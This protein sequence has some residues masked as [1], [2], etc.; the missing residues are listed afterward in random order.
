MSIED[1]NGPAHTEG[2]AT[3]RD[4]R[5]PR[6]TAPEAPPG[7]RSSRQ[8]RSAV[9]GYLRRSLVLATATIILVAAAHAVATAVSIVGTGFVAERDT[10]AYGPTS[11]ITT[12]GPS[13]AELWYQS[14]SSLGGW[15]LVALGVMLLIVQPVMEL[16]RRWTPSRGLAN[17]SGLAAVATA[18]VGFGVFYAFGGSVVTWI[19]GGTSAAPGFGFGTALAVLLFG[20]V[21]YG[22]PILIVAALA[23]GLALLIDRRGVRTIAAGVAGLIVAVLIVTSTGAFRPPPAQD[24]AAAQ[25]AEAV[26]GFTRALDDIDGISSIE[27]VGAGAT[28]TMAL[29]ASVGDVIS[30]ADAAKRAGEQ[31]PGIAIVVIQREEDPSSTA[32]QQDPARGPWRV[33]LVPSDRSADEIADELQRLMLTERLQV[34]ISLTE[35]LPLVT[36]DS[37]EVLPAAVRELRTLYPEGA[38]YSVPGRF[39]MTDDPSRLNT[40]MV[41]VI[42]DIVTAY[43]AVKIEVNDDAKL[44]I[45]GVKPDE[46]P[47]IIA[48]LQEPA[49]AGTSPTG[50]PADYVIYLSGDGDDIDGTF[51]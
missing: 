27:V 28:V 40:A 22:I 43:P 44:F 51:G 15:L 25:R 35:G 11:P 8:V 5:A 47:A 23:L 49:L 4:A 42:L 37:M 12:G 39:T 26:Q 45:G 38:H 1:A 19:A 14:L 6:D 29:D 21:V 46:A 48:M 10:G 33:Q 3:D 17:L 18:G 31:L 7:E 36:A 50:S 9:V 41:D 20:L 32:Q 2:D 34:R 30:A 24:V 13:E 16:V